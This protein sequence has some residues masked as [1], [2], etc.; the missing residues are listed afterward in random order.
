MSG[1]RPREPVA[2]TSR[3]GVKAR[4][5]RRLQ[6]GVRGLIVVVACCGVIMWAARS[7]WEGQHPSIAAARGLRSR[8]PSDR[9]RAAREL[10]A[11]GEV[12]PGLAI[13]P[14]IAA[15]GDPEAEVR[16]AAV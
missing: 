11:A 6:T 15:L 12:E 9:A 3:A 7:L 16:V 5:P 1:E 10:A 8:D 14:L 4:N 2:E 13:P